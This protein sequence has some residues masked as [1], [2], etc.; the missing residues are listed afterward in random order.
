VPS[1][2]LYHLK[3]L[4]MVRL[5]TRNISTFFAAHK[6]SR[7][8]RDSS[9]WVGTVYLWAATP[10]LTM[11]YSQIQFGTWLAHWQRHFTVIFNTYVETHERHVLYWTNHIL[12]NHTRIYISDRCRIFL[13]HAAELFL[14][15][16]SRLW[17]SSGRAPCYR[18]LGRRYDRTHIATTY[19]NVWSSSPFD[20]L[21]F[22][23]SSGTPPKHCINPVHVYSGSRAGSRC[24]YY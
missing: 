4:W 5:S 7:G 19:T 13:W 23:S 18:R 9:Q 24:P 3:I 21:L 22:T 10:L 16:K 11:A 1:L 15:S 2:W 6:L 14:R 20:I 12:A 17:C 8:S